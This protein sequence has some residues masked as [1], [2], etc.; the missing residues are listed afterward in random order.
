MRDVPTV[1][2]KKEVRVAVVFFSNLKIE[3]FSNFIEKFLN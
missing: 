2:I 3:T 1:S